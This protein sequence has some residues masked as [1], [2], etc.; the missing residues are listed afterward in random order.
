MTGQALSGTITVP[1]AGVLMVFAAVVSRRTSAFGVRIPY[2]ERPTP[3]VIRRQRLL[4]LRRTTLVCVCA[5]AIVLIAWGHGSWW[6]SR[7]VLAGEVVANLVCLRLARRN[8]I[9]VK[10]AE[11][12]YAGLRQEVVTDT[13]WRENPPRFPVA[14]LLPALTVLVATLIIGILRYPHLPARLPRIGSGGGGPLVPKSPVAV[15]AVV[16][17][18]AYVIALWTWNL[19]LMYRA[20]PEIEARDPAGSAARHRALLAATA[21]AILTLIALLNVTLL[22]VAL[23]Q[24]RLWMVPAGLIVVPFL[25]GLIVLVVVLWRAAR[26]WRY[27]AGAAGPA[28]AEGV[29][30]RD[31]DRFWKLGVAYVNKD[32][33]AVVVAARFGIGWT[34]NWA[35]P[36]A[37]LLIAGILAVPAGLAVIGLATGA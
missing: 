34:L 16:I 31:D 20:R 28:A 36:R 33:P 4:Y 5:T 6:F 30:D 32:D 11:D 27:S 29:A 17:G 35:N 2:P 8:I 15:F 19:N 10:N 23:R 9:A 7:I 21:K 37:W 3:P 14:W 24:W 12:W 13:G 25:A 22:L 1:I 18:Q 26:S